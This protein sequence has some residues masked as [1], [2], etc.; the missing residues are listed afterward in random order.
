MDVEE[1]GGVDLRRI[2]DEYFVY[3]NEYIN[4]QNDG[5]K[6]EWMRESYDFI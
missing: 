1:G 4:I 2:N 6:R 3:A 5:S